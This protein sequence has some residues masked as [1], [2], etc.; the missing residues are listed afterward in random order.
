MLLASLFLCVGAWAQI[1]ALT[2]LNNSKAYLLKNA[3]DMGYAIWES[4]DNLTLCGAESTYTNYTDNLDATDAGS[5]WQIISYNDKYYLYNVGAE[6]FAVTKGGPTYLTT[7]P[8][9]IAIETVSKGF[10][11]NSTGESTHYMCAAHQSNPPVQFWYANDNGSAWQ[12]IENDNTASI[13]D[14]LKGAEVVKEY[15]NSQVQV[16]FEYYIDG[17]LYHTSEAVA[18]NLNIVPQ[19]PALDY[20]T[21]GATDVETIT[22]ACTVK[23]TCTENLPFVSSTDYANATWQ[24]ID[25]HSNEANYTWKYVAADADVETPNKAK[26]QNSSLGDEFYWAFVGNLVDGFKIYNKAAG[27]TLTLRKAENGNNASVMSAIDDRNVFKLHKSAS[28]SISNSFCFKIDGDTHYLNKQDQKLR[29]W[30]SK[31]EG[32]S[33]RMFTPASF[34]LNALGGFENAPCGAVGSYSYLADAEKYATF[35]TA[36]AAVKADQFDVE[37]LEA[38]DELNMIADIVASEKVP[39]TDGYYRI[40]NLFHPQAGV[41]NMIGVIEGERKGALG[42]LSNVDF[43]WNIKTSENGY[44]LENANRGLFM[45]SVSDQTLVEEANAAEYTFS[46]LGAAQWKIQ[47]GGNNLVMFYD[48]GTLGHW[49]AVAQNGDGAWYIIPATTVEYTLSDIN[50]AGYASA[51]LPFDVTLDKD[52]TAYAITEAANGYATLTEK[53]DIKANQGAILIGTPGRHTFEIATAS[54][55]W[56]G[57]LL[58][59]TTVNTY[60]E[61]SAYVLAK[62][63]SGVGLY[64]AML[65]KDANGNAVVEGETGTHFLNNANKAYL[66]VEGSNAPMFSFDRGEGTTSIDNAQLTMDNVVIYD[67]LGRR[68]EKMEKGIY[69]VNGKKIIK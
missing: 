37:A 38:L 31:D 18:H 1:S 40:Q 17:E 6:K 46:D 15:F 48:N 8:T 69:I 43:I 23:V 34:V 41:K 9:P 27:E 55:D 26:T 14:L 68:V 2:E 52:V 62:G 24:V 22:E 50:D 65:N 4:G 21:I 42:N 56:T 49:S 67:L 16:V 28:T 45:S 13:S 61:G 51:Y 19:V 35:S 66:V 11:F 36:I 7:T 3:N 33:C 60:V 32:S 12:I 53:D 39:L 63:D 44:T 25:M 57:N 47:S 10:A 20:V 59:G 64:K 30:T 58:K 5:N 54:S 29:G